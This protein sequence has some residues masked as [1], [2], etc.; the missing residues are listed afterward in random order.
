MPI[1]FWYIVPYTTNLI[2]NLPASSSYSYQPAT[3]EAGNMFGCRLFLHSALAN[4]RNLILPFASHDAFGARLSAK[5]CL[6]SI[7]STFHSCLP[8]NS[9]SIISIKTPKISHN[10]LF[11]WPFVPDP[12]WVPN[13]LLLL[14]T[15]IR[16]QRNSY[17]MYAGQRDSSSCLLQSSCEPNF[18][19]RVDLPSVK[20]ESLNMRLVLPSNP[21]QRGS[22]SESGFHHLTFATY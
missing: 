20:A 16:R 22:R 21:R 5:G 3:G 6:G 9:L 15:T 2:G 17:S 14:K 7:I 19:L 10:T 13:L 12:V 8:R 4:S 11:H 1:S 18:D